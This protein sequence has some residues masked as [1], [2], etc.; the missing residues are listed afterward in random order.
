MDKQRKLETAVVE[1]L[2]D[3]FPNGLSRAT[4]RGGSME[5]SL[6]PGTS[7][8]LSPFQPE[9]CKPGDLL[10]Y[11]RREQNVIHRMVRKYRGQDGMLYILRGDANG[12]DDPPVREDQIIAKAASAP[13]RTFWRS[14]IQSLRRFLT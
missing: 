7:L 11:R 5:P 6:R 1:L 9:Q 3:A 13:Q 10:V 2:R 8:A 14:L 12:S 4:V